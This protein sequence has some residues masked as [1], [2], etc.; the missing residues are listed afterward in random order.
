MTSKALSQNAFLRPSK[1]QAESSQGHKGNTQRKSTV[2]DAVAGRISTAGF[3]PKRAVFSST[4]DT[5]SS[6]TTPS[7]PED[8][9]FRHKNAP[10]RFAESDVYF[11]NERAA[12]IELPDS[13]L[14]KAIHSYASD[15]YSRASAES[16]LDWRS[17]DETALIALG[18]LMEEASKES[19]GRTGDLVFTEGEEVDDTPESKPGQAV[20]LATSSENGRPADIGHKKRRRIQVFD[21]S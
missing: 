1:T 4:R 7:A 11:A 15:F 16:S 13:D 12:P 17:L 5:T 14:L 2:Y 18:V 9:L 10:T 3:I 6:T 20:S 19:L 21:E 8:I